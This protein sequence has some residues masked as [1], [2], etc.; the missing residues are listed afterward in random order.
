MTVVAVSCVDGRRAAL[1][2]LTVLTVLIGV[3]V[4]LDTPERIA[5]ARDWARLHGR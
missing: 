5:L 4:V 2:A 1:L 3:L